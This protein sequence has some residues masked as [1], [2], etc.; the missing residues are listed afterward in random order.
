MQV[1]LRES[2]SG[3]VNLSLHQHIGTSLAQNDAMTKRSHDQMK[4]TS[5]MRPTTV[6]L[7]VGLIA[8][9]GASPAAAQRRG[10]VPDTGMAAIGGSIGA[11]VPS[12]ANLQ[13]G[14]ELAGSAEGYLTPRVSI[15]GQL[16]GTWWDIT[17]R[18]FTGTFKPVFIDGNVVYNWEGG[19][20]HP[21]VTGGFGLYHY[22]FDIPAAN[23]TDNRFGGDVGGGVEFFFR[24]H[25]TLT[26]EV[27]YHAVTTPAQSPLGGFES[28]FWT[29]SMGVK[30]YFR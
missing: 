22:G 4:P 5:T 11:S 12:D 2:F 18:H 20:I 16:G 21:Y 24:R 15:R 27:L 29:V 14:V 19:A 23:G 3:Q 13:N 6:L 17:G 1:L 28:R 7:A 25:A 30:R 9:I 10:R 8:S 26:G